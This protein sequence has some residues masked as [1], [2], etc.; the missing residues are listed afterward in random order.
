MNPT[1]QARRSQ[2]L[3]DDQQAIRRTLC[4]MVAHREAD[5]EEL[6]ELSRELLDMLEWAAWGN[7]INPAKLV[8][9][10]CRARQLGVTK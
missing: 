1:Q 10:K 9:C 5:M 2:A 4:D 6:Q 8:K 3:Y 7:E